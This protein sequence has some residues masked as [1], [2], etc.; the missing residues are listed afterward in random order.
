MIM[1]W[2]NVLDADLKV[3]WCIALGASLIFVIQTVMTFVGLDGSEGISADF[4]GNLDD[5]GGPGQLF[6]LRNLINFLLGYGWAAICFHHVISSSL[7]LNVVAIVVGIAFVL[8]FFLLMKQMTRLQA[9]KT[10]R[11][12]HTLGKSADVYLA[13]PAEMSGRGK[14]QVSVGGAYHEL[15]AMTRGEK[16]PT[17]SKARI[18]E[19]IDGQTLL[20]SKLS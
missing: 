6:S 20:V 9:D 13:I 18:D 12:E 14:V 15:N 1:E 8:L 11:L 17:G 16:L 5:A 7:W 10:F 19:L 4:D 3:Y 2:F